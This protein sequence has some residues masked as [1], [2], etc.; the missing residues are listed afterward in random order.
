MKINY[1]TVIA[2]IL[3]ALILAAGA[4]IWE[5]VSEGALIRNLGGVTSADL[6]MV[7]N[8]KLMCEA[9]VSEEFEEPPTCSAGYTLAS[10]CSGDCNAD[11]ARVALCCHYVMSSP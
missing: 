5:S 6:D 8:R 7:K 3:I 4:I 10:W 11:D 2:P 1:S 9:L